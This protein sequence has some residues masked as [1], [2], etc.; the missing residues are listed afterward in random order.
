M[1]F[2]KTTLAL[3]IACTLCGTAHQ[4]VA[5][6]PAKPFT[7]LTG[8]W[9]N[10][11]L[12]PD[13]RSALLLAQMTQDEKLKLVISHFGSDF[14]PKGTKKHPKALPH[15]AAYVEGVP[16]LG[17]PDL[18][19]TDAGIGVATQGSGKAAPRERTA[20][21]SGLGTAAT[22]NRE[23]ALQGGAMIGAEA[24]ASGFNVMLAGGV[25]LQ[26]EPRNGRNFE[27]AGEDP[28][29]A[30]TMVGLQI[31]G[32]QSNHIVST[33]KHFA[34]NS[35]E[36]GRFVLDARLDDA[37]ARMSDLLALQFAMEVGDP[38]SV[39]CAYNRVNG[40]YA[41]ESNYLLKE[42]LK[43]DW[44]F[45]GYVMSDWGAVHSTV[46]AANS[47]LDQQSGWEFDASQYFGGALREA[48]ENGAVAQSRLDDMV[49]R[50][51][52]A[53][54]ATGVMDHPVAEGGAIDYAAHAL[55]SRSDAEEAMVLLKNSK[56]LL[57]L[58][59]NV[60]KIVV[61][62]AHADVGV[63]SGGGSSQVYPVG[64]MAVQ[65]LEPSSW[66]GPVVYFPSSPLAHIRAQAPK[67]DVT[68]HDGRDAKAAARLA[69][70]ADVVLVFADQWI[71]EANDARSLSLPNNQDALIAAVAGA[72]PN[73]AVVLLTGGPVTMPWLD[74]VG[75][76]L[77]A[78]YPGSSGGE[79]IARVLFGV[80]NPS[81]RL[82]A[83]FPAAESQ[84]PR[85]L[86][87]GDRE[88][89]HKRFSVNYF[90]GASVGY[91][92]FDA[93]GLTPLFPF[94]YGLSYTSFGYSDLKSEVKGGNLH[95]SFKVS[96]KGSVAGKEVAQI[97]VAP[98]KGGWE[99]PKRLGGW[100]KVDLAPGQTKQLS[101][102][103]DPR[104]LAMFDS[105]SK[106]WRVAA[107]QYEV[108][109]AQH[110]GDTQASRVTVSLP[111]RT[112]DARG[113]DVK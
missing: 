51:L 66:P 112:L 101:L 82:P 18:F 8:A 9:S 77:A 37:G 79:A 73:T 15:S 42:V 83:T 110:A 113:K 74:Q 76:V 20:L 38:G 35:Q 1:T 97:Y 54:Y 108:M 27:Y 63:L 71:G 44:G 29:L 105:K 70:G 23:L 100:D 22:W 26:R 81:G 98:V 62:G 80:V 10:R 65:G 56:K 91:K 89:E 68:F 24:R 55:V 84:L 30:G 3:A 107:G 106:R 2:S 4:A 46:A 109:L 53:L 58:N 39:M 12:D 6:D 28:L 86:L 72:N 96:N 59:A 61:I 19:E 11:A 16:R 103:V 25:N 17:I 57:P 85:P 104:L 88:N 5:A 41:C 32:I 43:Q 33:L 78:W 21:P 7:V 67:A 47:G 40:V 87:D 45:K 95:V 64:G 93:K 102:V 31:K 14:E 36:T 48:V 34:V 90:E 50:I 13:Q 69:A 75:A 60:R 111:K 99:A 49:K 92:W 94:G 52:R